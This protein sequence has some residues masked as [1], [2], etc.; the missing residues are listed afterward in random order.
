MSVGINKSYMALQID[1]KIW[2]EFKSCTW[3]TYKIHTDNK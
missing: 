2:P 1:F 3:M